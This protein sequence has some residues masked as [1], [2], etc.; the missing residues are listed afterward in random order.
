MQPFKYGAFIVLLINISYAHAGIWDEIKS[1]FTTK[2]SQRV[3]QSVNS[4]NGQ[5]TLEIEKNTVIIRNDK[6]DVVQIIDNGRFYVKSASFLDSGEAVLIESVANGGFA[7]FPVM[8]KLDEGSR[9]SSKPIINTATAIAAPTKNSPDDSSHFVQP[10]GKLIWSQVSKL[11]FSSKQASSVR[12]SPN[13]NLV[14]VISEAGNVL[15]TINNGRFWVETAEFSQDGKSVI[16]RS[17]ANGG[18]NKYDLAYPINLFM[19]NGTDFASNLNNKISLALKAHQ[20]LPSSLVN[21]QRE[22]NIQK[23]LLNHRAQTKIEKDEFESSDAF[24]ARARQVQNEYETMVKDY[25]RRVIQYE[26]QLKAHYNNLGQLPENARHQAIR[27]AF[28]ESYGPPIL[29]RVHYDADTQSF[30]AELSEHLRGDLKK[31]IILRDIPPSHARQLKP[32]LEQA[33]GEVIFRI[34]PD[35]SLTWET[36]TVQTAT[37]KLAA[38]PVD[39]GGQSQK[40]QVTIKPMEI[41]TPKVNIPQ[42]ISIGKIEVAIKDDPVIAARQAEI[43]RIRREQ[44]RGVAREAELKRLEEELVR[45]KAD[46]PGVYQDD[47]PERL[48]KIPQVPTNPRLH[49]LAVGIEDYADVAD[50][51]FAN[52]SARQFAAVAEKTLGVPSQNVMLLTNDEATGTRIKGR[53]NTLLN[54]LGPQDSLLVYYAGHGVPDSA[55]KAAYLL[56]QDAGPGSFED[57]QLRL[58]TFYRKLADSK[59]G[60]V[61]VFMDACFTGR[62]ENKRMV[63]EGVAPV[64][65]TPTTLVPDNSR[66]TVMTATGKQQFANQAKDV[67]HRL[68][69][70]HLMRG[71]LA[72]KTDIADLA[73]YVEDQVQ[74]DSRRLGPEFEQI[75][76]LMGRTTGRLVV[77]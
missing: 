26:H 27:E 15:Q 73:R 12:L 51:P 57:A 13:R 32:G 7:T 18:V 6:G 65:L 75:P 56:P 64:M 40:L 11:M 54:R 2:P 71:L 20:A 66:L 43:D 47:L 25:N 52:R 21:Q 76:E 16:V 31:T 14:N 35:N 68:F 4:D 41:A 42:P 22:L 50:V 70:Y 5:L 60:R 30:Y 37:E 67:G 61:T 77:K 46:S 58:D 53:M 1:L 59:A 3:T 29:K 17:V 62:A 39:I 28:M 8:T 45:L 48:A 63:F 49:L 24:N 69:G 36:I 72:G 33:K 10:N 55:G 38:L 34:N 19:S 23:D 9:S 74:A 44:A